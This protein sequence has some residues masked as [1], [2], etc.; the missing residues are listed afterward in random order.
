M[1]NKSTGKQLEITIDLQGSMFYTNNLVSFIFNNS[2]N[3]KPYGEFIIID[4]NSDAL[5]EMTGNFG[6]IIFSNV[7]DSVEGKSSIIN[8]VVDAMIRLTTTN[9]N[10]TYKILWSAGTEVSLKKNT[11]AVNGNSIDAMLE[12]GKRYGI[13]SS[14]T[15]SVAN[16]N[17]PVD[18]MTWRYVSDD[19]WDSFDRTVNR[20]YFGND[21]VFWA[22]DDINNYI[23]LS[24]FEFEYA[25]ED[26]AILTFSE[27][28]KTSMDA[29][30]IILDKPRLSIWSYGESIRFNNLGSSRDKLFPNVAFSGVNDGEMNKAGCVG[31]C[32]DSVLQ[33]T[34]NN[35]KEQVLTQTGFSDKNAVYGGLKVIRNYPNN[36][37]KMYSLAPT[38]RDYVKSMYAKS[39]HV[40]LYNNI[41][42]EIGS[43]VSVITYANDRKLYGPVIDT[44]YTDSYIIA[45]KIISMN[46]VTPTMTGAMGTKNSNEITVVL[47]LISKNMNNEG[48]EAVNKLY[49]AIKG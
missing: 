17:K 42:P 15:L 35:T 45:D 48:F 5:Y 7:D 38:V 33:S 23:K 24:S 36:T 18:A 30:R 39:L 37:H 11:W 46:N 28:A 21:Y 25:K 34:G 3:S 26:S 32:F 44:V 47:K 49:A 14:E 20:S 1:A 40:Y 13:K 22:Y 27:N 29:S 6:S 31:P 9:T 12:V 10:S 4:T 16:Y 2:I 41:G 8:F 43:K 19:I